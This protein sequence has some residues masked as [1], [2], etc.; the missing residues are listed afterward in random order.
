MFSKSIRI[1]SLYGI[2]VKVHWSFSL[3]LIYVIWIT[4]RLNLN[5]VES[6]GV[7]AFFLVLFLC[8]LAH[9][10]G[11]A[12]VAKRY[13]VS[14]R[15][16]ILLPIGG[17][18]RL[19]RSPLKAM[20]EF[21]IALAGPMVNILI[22]ILL[23]IYLIVFSDKGLFNPVESTNVFFSSFHDFLRLIFITNLVLF[24]F[25]LLPAY[26]MDG[27]RMLRSLISLKLSRVSSTKI[28]SLIGQI[29]AIVF[30]FIG[31]YF[32]QIFILLI[33]F[34]VLLTALFEFRMASFFGKMEK[35][36]VSDCMNTIFTRYHLH[37]KVGDFLT[38]ADEWSLRLNPV[39]ELE[40]QFRGFVDL[41]VLRNSPLIKIEEEAM[42]NY[43]QEFTFFLDAEDSAKKA[44]DF[45]TMG[46]EEAVGIKDDGVIIGMLTLDI[47]KNHFGSIRKI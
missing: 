25:N 21:A 22:A 18:A 10:F 38:S 24:A 26:P 30:I 33:G 27:G 9:E 8:V 3:I 43:V 12:L 47:L 32:S 13:G 15:D 35:I 28:A 44:Y 1:F 14:T 45:L 19:S 5:K 36:K 40:T 46:G 7:L 6:F 23:A 34:F 16:I 17:L 42:T 29:L 41:N 31:I 39:I 20:H 37:Q 4:Q 2:P 11:H